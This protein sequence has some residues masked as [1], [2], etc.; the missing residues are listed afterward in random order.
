MAL[1]ST[2]QDQ[3]RL[4]RVYAAEAL[5]K[6]QHEIAAS[7]PVLIDAMKDEDREV[8]GRARL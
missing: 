1:Q 7:L 3:N 8:R 6:I 2:L 5:W 4:V